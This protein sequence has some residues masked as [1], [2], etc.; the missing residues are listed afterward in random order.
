MAPEGVRRPGRDRSLDAGGLAQASGG[1]E[2][3][4]SSFVAMPNLLPAPPAG[5]AYRLQW[6]GGPSL[7]VRPGFSSGELAS[8]LRLLRNL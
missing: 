1:Q 6:P 8:L 7:E 5:P 4:G 3:G 2:G